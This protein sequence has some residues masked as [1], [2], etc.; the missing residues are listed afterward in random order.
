MDL[1]KTFSMPIPCKPIFFQGLCLCVHTCIDLK[2]N[3]VYAI[4][5][6]GIFHLLHGDRFS[7]IFM[8][9]KGFFAIFIGYR[10]RKS[11]LIGN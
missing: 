8:V 7:E 4:Q 10:H 9:H 6:F 1:K 5:E 3:V 11:S 2:K